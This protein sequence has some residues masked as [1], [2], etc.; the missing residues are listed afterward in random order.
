MKFR[1]WEHNCNAVQKFSK[2]KRKK[3]VLLYWI[4]CVPNIKVLDS[5]R[6]L[7]DTQ[8]YQAGGS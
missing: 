3:K 4:N 8:Q 7:L 1:S 2:E 5:V 6:I